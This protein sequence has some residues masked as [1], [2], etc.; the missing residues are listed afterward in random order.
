MNCS[1]CGLAVMTN[2]TFCHHCGAPLGS[3]TSS[4][5]MLPQQAQATGG[6][7]CVKCGTLVPAGKRF[8]IQCGTPAGAAIPI[9]RNAVAQPLSQQASRAPVLPRS[10]TLQDSLKGLGIRI[11]TRQVIGFVVSVV[12]GL[13]VARVLPYVYPLFFSWFLDLVF[14]PGAG[15]RDTFNWFLMTVITFLVTFVTAFAFSWRRRAAR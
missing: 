11:S 1:N 13:I 8:C 9:Q 5:T 7:P 12:V 3:S 10:K 14:G 15:W 4:V 6:L 2:A